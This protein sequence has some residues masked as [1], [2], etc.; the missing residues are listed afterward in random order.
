MFLNF[1]NLKKFYRYTMSCVSLTMFYDEEISTSV[2]KS[3][4][5]ADFLDFYN[6]GCKGS[7]GDAK[8]QKQMLAKLA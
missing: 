1:L 6:T 2:L 7:I 8:S 4:I 3:L 5:S